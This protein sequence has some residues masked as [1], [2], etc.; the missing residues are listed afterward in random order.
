MKLKEPQL[1]FL[2][3]YLKMK[4]HSYSMI[5]Y[6]QTILILS[7]HANVFFKI[8]ETDPIM[9]CA[10]KIIK[11]YSTGSTVI[12]I[13]KNNLFHQ[14]VETNATILIYSEDKFFITTKFNS[15]SM[16]I[17]ILNNINTYEKNLN[18]IYNSLYWNSQANFL[19]ANYGNVNDID[20]ILT[21]SWKY[22]VLNINVITEYNYDVHIYTFFPYKNNICAKYDKY[23]NISTCDTIGINEIFPS[24]IPP[25]LHG[26]EVK[27]M[28]YRI[29]PYVINVNA[30]RENPREAGIEV[31]IFHTISKIMNFSVNYINNP[32]AHWGYRYNDGTYTFMYK[33]LFE[34]RTDLI[35]GFIYANASFTMDFDTSFC[36]LEDQSLWYYPIALP[37][38]QWKNLSAIFERNLWIAIF[39]MLLIN[40]VAWWFIGKKREKINEYNDII[41]C[42]M[43]SL[44]I[45]LQGSVRAPEKGNLRLMFSLWLMS[46]LLLYTAHQS[47]LISILTNPLYD[48]QMKT[49][50]DLFESKME[51]GFFPNIAESY[52]N[53]N[54]TKDQKILKEYKQCP[55]TVECVNRTAF[56]RDFAVVKSKRQ[57]R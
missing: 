50:D 35:F 29:L 40:S 48:K 28:V 8:T 46:C 52:E 31:T 22:N 45:L 42:M 21:I 33:T 23:E 6:F 3:T 37:I 36:Y 56:K 10:F 43:Q 51:F 32:Y 25:D 39:F 19:I 5:I 14:K 27:A 15:F 13:N 55:L 2:G 38:S 20:K 16:F 9:T 30:T 34:H 11:K 47:Q 41:L 54:N 53:S 18:I 1:D 57:V 24:K 44:Y 12:I 17:F 4:I 7:T 49:L 26:C